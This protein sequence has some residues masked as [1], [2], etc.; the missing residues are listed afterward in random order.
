MKTTLRL[1][2]F[3][4]ISL[5]AVHPS[6]AQQPT[7]AQ[8]PTSSL[9]EQLTPI[10]S[11]V[12]AKKGK[13][14]CPRA[15]CVILVTDFVSADGSTSRF[16]INTSDALVAALASQDHSL[17]F[18]DRSSLHAFLGEQRILPRLANQTGV[19]RWL[20]RKTNADVVITGELHHPRADN[21]EL[22]IHVAIA[23]I[24]ANASLQFR[25][26]LHEEHLNLDPYDPL[27]PLPPLSD[28]VNGQPVYQNSRS[29]PHAAFASPKCSMPD[30]SYTQEARDMRFSGAVLVE[31]LIDLQG[32]VT[33]VRIIQGAPGGLNDATLK[34]TDTWKC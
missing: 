17:T 8:Q 7:A 18:I 28:T 24:F 15:A 13:L 21:V 16:A 6:L 25:T 12:L 27:P 34:I 23:N 26:N 10:A 1:L 9:T 2:L 4:I 19:A 22:T 5:L 20:A 3:P 30:P 11:Q 29:T 31:T 14:E 33:P 32:R